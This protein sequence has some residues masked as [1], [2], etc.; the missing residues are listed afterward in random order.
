MGLVSGQSIRP[1]HAGKLP[2]SIAAFLRLYIA[3]QKLTAEAALTGD[4]R[5]ALQAF[6]LDPFV[7]GNLDL[8]KIP[9][10][11]DEMLLAHADNLPQFK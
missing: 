8:D 10:L 6:E 3:S 7:A 5:I 4:R 11:L 9:L 2:E 1:I